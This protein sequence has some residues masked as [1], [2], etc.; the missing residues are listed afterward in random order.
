MTTYETKT[1]AQVPQRSTS[2]AMPVHSSQVPSLK[3]RVHQQLSPA[4]CAGIPLSALSFRQLKASDYEEM[5]ALHTEWFP[6]SYDE[7]FYSKSVQGELFTLVATHSSSS[8]S[9]LGDAGASGD[10][11]H[12]SILGMITM[13]T[14]CEHHCEDIGHILG[15]DCSS[16]CRNNNAPRRSI[17]EPRGNHGGGSGSLAYILTL[18][19]ADGFRRRGLATE[20]LKRSVEHVDREMAHVQAVYLHVVTYNEPAIRLYEGQRFDRIKHFEKFYF[21]H[22]RHYDSFLYAFYLHG[23]H[24]PWK[25]RFRNMLSLGPWREWITSTWSSWWQ[26]SCDKPFLNSEGQAAESP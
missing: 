15:G 23:A 13:S 1:A 9:G 8:S 21:L 2:S 20:L 6:V 17:T 18:G 3:A 22:G 19:V 26:S 5:V 4:E 7:A 11:A 24:P 10:D 16:I 14:Y 25:W 12:E